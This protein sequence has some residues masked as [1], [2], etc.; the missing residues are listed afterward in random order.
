MTVHLSCC[1]GS[2]I[3]TVSFHAQNSMV[4][5]NACNPPQPPPPL[6]YKNFCFP[7]IKYLRRGQFTLGRRI[8]NLCSSKQGD[9]MG[10]Y[11][12][13]IPFYTMHHFPAAYWEFTKFVSF[14]ILLSPSPLMKRNLV[15]SN[16]EKMSSRF[17]LLCILTGSRYTLENLLICCLMVVYF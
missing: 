8:Y 9:N 15:K 6:D 4:I 3:P 13:S 10:Q 16:L 7:K 1:I 14:F 12:K 11:K 17:L 5:W 2:L